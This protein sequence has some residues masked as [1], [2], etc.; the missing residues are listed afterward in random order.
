MPQWCGTGV[1]TWNQQHQALREGA[2]VQGTPPSCLSLED[3]SGHWSLL[4]TKT[5]GRPW[6]A[7]TPQAQQPLKPHPLLL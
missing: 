6:L 1:E 2:C 5:E 4:V 7:T 3:T